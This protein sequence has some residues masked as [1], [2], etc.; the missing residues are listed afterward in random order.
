LLFFFALFAF[1]AVQNWVGGWHIGED[2]YAALGDANGRNYRS[3]YKSGHGRT[4]TG[5][6]ILER[7]S[8]EQMAFSGR[9]GFV[10]D[11]G[12]GCFPRGFPP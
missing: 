12:V 7:S 10:C 4:V 6:P 11:C 1:F 3:C 8:T 5:L 2:I 9:D